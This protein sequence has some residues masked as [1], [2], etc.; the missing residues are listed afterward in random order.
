MFIGWALF[1]LLITVLTTY[2]LIDDYI[3][4]SAHMLLRWDTLQS[5][6]IYVYNSLPG[7]IVNYLNTAL[8]GVWLWL[9]EIY[10]LTVLENDTTG[11]RHIERKGLAG[12]IIAAFGGGCAACGFTFL[13]NILGGVLGGAL[14][15]LPLGGAEIGIIGTVLLSISILRTYRQIN[16]YTPGTC[17]TN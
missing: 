8:F 12:S 15:A 13:T 5:F 10:R 1:A 2:P 4:R 11:K 17:P 7:G 3:P 9:T 16:S 14:G 6:L